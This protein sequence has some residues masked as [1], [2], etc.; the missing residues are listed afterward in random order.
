MSVSPEYRDF[1]IE[2]FSSV[3]AVRVR[4]MFG[5]AGIYAPTPDGK[6][7]MFGLIADET[8]Y[9]KVNDANRGDFE[10]E[11][12]GPFTYE[13]DG[14]KPITMSYYEL[15]PRLYDEPD[16]L[17]HWARKALDAALAARKPKKPRRK[18]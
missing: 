3:G 11:G 4:N 16:D 17:N 18:K 13:T 2:L 1:I 14:R 12:M 15:P 8:V 6:G 5:G 10:A 7:V 9:L